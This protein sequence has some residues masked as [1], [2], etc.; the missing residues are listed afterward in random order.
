MQ[1]L[2]CTSPG[3]FEYRSDPPPELIEGHAIIRVRRV[4][5]CGTDLHA[6]EGTQ[7][8]FT[9]P[10][11]LGHELA[12]DLIECNGAADFVPGEE[13]T[14]IP[15]FFCG[16]CIACRNGKTNCCVSV[17][18][19]GVHSDGG[20]REYIRVPSYSLVHGK[21][22]GYDEL[23]L[24][25]PLAIGAHAVR[26]AGVRKGENVV[27][28]GAGPIGIGIAL[29]AE[30][31]GAN[32]FVVDVNKNRLAFCQSIFPGSVT[33]DASE[34]NPTE[35]LS[36]HTS[37]DMPTVVFDAT[38]NLNAMQSAFDWIAHTGRYV[39]V[40]LQKEK[41]SFSH[42]E[43]HKREATLMSSRNATREDFDLVLQCLVEK[44]FP[45]HKYITHHPGFLQ[46]AAEFSSLTDPSSQVI[47]AIVHFD[48][49]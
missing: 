22:L 7:P 37:G 21:G 34:V 4:G 43:F 49:E 1:S 13:V 10:R 38:G 29:F 23:A 35:T 5:I 42:P 2:V 40:G 33:I 3:N 47:K 25:E 24:A 46:L 48:T 11:I 32:V 17:N 44:K 27:I 30:L 28:T 26:R 45:F 31:A 39:L 15:Y 19:F 12:G 9:Y 20:M 41:I 6:Y 36:F 14:I 16:K 18:V 8:Y